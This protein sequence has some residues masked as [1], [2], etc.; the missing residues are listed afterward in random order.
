MN[1]VRGWPASVRGKGQKLMGASSR[2]L[3]IWLASVRQGKP[4]RGLLEQALDVQEDRSC[5]VWCLLVRR[6]FHLASLPRQD[7]L[8]HEC[9]TKF[10]REVL[11]RWLGDLYVAHGAPDFVSPDLLGWPATRRRSLGQKFSLACPGRACPSS[12]L[13]QLVRAQ[14]ST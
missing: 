14:R 5:P 12:V 9:T 4:A 10:R 13:S 6:L 7:V 1:S 8:L 2:Y 11:E 3:A